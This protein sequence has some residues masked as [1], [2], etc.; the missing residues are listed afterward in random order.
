[1]VHLDQN[2]I[3]SLYRGHREKHHDCHGLHV[4]RLRYQRLCVSDQQNHHGHI[5][6]GSNAE[7]QHHSGQKIKL[8]RQPGDD[9]GQDKEVQKTSHGSGKMQAVKIKNPDPQ[10][11]KD[12]SSQDVSVMQECGIHKRSYVF[13]GR[14]WLS[15]S[16]IVLCWAFEGFC[17]LA[18]L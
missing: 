7:L 17:W 16:P 4:R 2:I 3:K 18:E 14:G 6:H 9:I 8:I 10:A 12:N 1:M 11:I 13:L 5:D 15:L